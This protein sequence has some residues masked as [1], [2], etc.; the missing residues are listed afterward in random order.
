M[1]RTVRSAKLETRTARLEKLALRKKPYS[2][3]TATPGVILLYRRNQGPGVW[4][5]R[6][7]SDGKD[8]T[9]RLGIAD[10]YADADGAAVL[11][12][13]QALH[14]A[15]AKAKE[16]AGDTK[17][18]I[19]RDAL[20][21]YEKDLKTRGGDTGNVTR[22]RFHLSEEILGKTLSSLKAGELK[23]WRDDLGKKV[24]PST[25]NRTATCLRAALNLIADHDERVARRPWEAGLQ[26]LRDVEQS[27]NVILV[28]RVVRLIVE[29]AYK[30][31]ELYKPKYQTFGLLVELAALTGARVSQLA[32]L[33]VQ[34]VQGDRH[35]PR[36]MLPSSRKGRGS[37]KIF[38]RPVPITAALALRLRQ[39]GANRPGNAPLLLRAGKEPWP[40]SGHREPF[41]SVI[42]AVRERIEKEF[43]DPK[44]R[45][46][47]LAEIDGAT[48]YA[49]RHSNIVRQLL[50][51][52]PIRVVAVNHD[53]SV[54]M[55]ERTYSRHIADHADELS[56]KAL[57][58]IAAPASNV[59]P[60]SAS[61]FPL[62]RAQ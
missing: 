37:K 52:V 27:R 62:K 24:S 17:P 35:D 26:A 34:D 36:L 54:V 10:D 19:V 30:V 7:A 57:I 41:D 16:W 28:D 49:L 9:L 39:L 51:S 43:Q 13:K 4:I 23:R 2:S 29:A 8:R 5:V 58:E 60:I 3:P 59:T 44:E 25:V 32:R 61:G 1:A 22:V 15:D 47:R 48:L 18:A 11:N 31:E 20:D 33:E 12:Y 50:A 42:T 45:E 46:K 6:L 40:R 14:A 55:I 21:S 53:T 56:R 38:R